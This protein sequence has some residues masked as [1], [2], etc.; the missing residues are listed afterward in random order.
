MYKDMCIEMGG[1]AA[2]GGISFSCTRFE[3]DKRKWTTEKPFNW[4]ASSMLAKDFSFGL[5]P[6]CVSL[7]FLP[8][9]CM[10]HYF[11]IAWETTSVCHDPRR[12]GVNDNFF[13]RIRVFYMN[14]TQN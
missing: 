9:L 4:P 12:F 5:L 8:E 14:S 2:C 13:P 3:R 6:S 7:K 1:Q 11:T 10:P